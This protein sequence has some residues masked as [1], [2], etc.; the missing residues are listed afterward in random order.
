MKQKILTT[1]LAILLVLPLVFGGTIINVSPSLEI[2]S[3]IAG[4]TTSTVFSFDYPYVEENYNNAPLVAKVDISCLDEGEDCPLDNCSVLKGDFQLNM[5]AEQYLILGL[6]HYNTI[7]MPCYETAPIQ[8]KAKDKPKIQ[9]TIDNV[10]EGTFYCY[11]PNYYMMQLD[12][13]DEI[14]LEISSDPA[15]YPGQYSVSVDLLEMEPDYTGPEIEL[16]EP[17]GEDIFPGE[18]GIIPIK[19]NITDMYA[20]DSETV[21]YKIV[22]LGVPSD[23]EGLNM[24]YYD[25][26][27][28]YEIE[29]NEISGYYEADFDMEDHELT[30]SGS[31]W[32]YAEAKDVLGNEGKL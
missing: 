28:I 29:Y 15:L 7:P 16:I 20:I 1:I 6:F 9:Y 17:S 12:S 14:T 30:E 2:P 13:H 19:L 8:F 18:N 5:I 27:W 3:F 26:G 21:R 10:P 11:N 24:D 32:I 25:S 4:D 22:T 23:G 31:Y